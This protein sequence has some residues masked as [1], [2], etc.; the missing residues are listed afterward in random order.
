MDNTNPKNIRKFA[1]F[2]NIRKKVKILNE[3]N[4]ELE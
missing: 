2:Q 4:K 3:E 1:I